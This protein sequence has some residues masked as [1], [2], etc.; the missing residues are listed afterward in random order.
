MPKGKVIPFAPRVE[1]A[2]LP[3]RKVFVMARPVQMLRKAA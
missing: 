1:V 2:K 3:G